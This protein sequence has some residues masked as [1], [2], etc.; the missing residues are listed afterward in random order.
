MPRL[1]PVTNIAAK[2][3][4]LMFEMPKNSELVTETG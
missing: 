1:A 4:L 2:L 3:Y